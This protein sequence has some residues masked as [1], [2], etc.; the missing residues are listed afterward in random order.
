VRTIAVLNL[1]GGVGKTTTSL[2]L[3]VGAAAR[4]MEVLLV[5]A[6]P[7]ANS[8][9]VMLDGSA[10][11]EPTLGHVLLDRAEA[12]E[13]IRPSRV[14]HVDILPADGGLADAALL[15]AEQL[16]RERRLRSA[17][18]SVSSRYDLVVIDCP[19]QLTLITINVMNA[20]HEL[21]IPID[22]GAFAIAGLVRLGE[23][24]DQVRRHLDNKEL[25]VAGLALVRT[26][27]NKATEDLERQLRE[28]YGDLVYRTTI[29]HSV[30]V[31]EAH[32]RHRSI[33]EFAPQSPPAL[34]YDRLLMDIF[35]HVYQRD[36]GRADPAD[37]ADA[38]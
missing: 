9:A 31:E 22:A 8:T 16:G 6:D 5:D 27:R 32:A 15:L 30:R 38:A 36:A 14:A 20:A 29:P 3:A 1:K 28:A 35:K 13:A 25:K 11:D 2:S 10:A 4:G 33:S 26:H 19:P 37:D 18:Q 12:I 17:L 21:V 24:I 34:A 7:Q 23:A